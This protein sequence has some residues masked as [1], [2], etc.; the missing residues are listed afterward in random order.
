[1]MAGCDKETAAS[2][3]NNDGMT[4]GFNGQSKL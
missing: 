1:M 3:M 2:M 4:G